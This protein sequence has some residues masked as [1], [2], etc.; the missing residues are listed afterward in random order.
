MTGWSAG[1]A[2]DLIF[3]YGGND[4]L[5]GNGGDDTLRGGR[6]NDVLHGGAGADAL[7]D[8]ATERTAANGGLNLHNL[9]DGGAD[10][11]ILSSKTTVNLFVTPIR[12]Q[13]HGQPG[14][15]PGTAGGRRQ[16]PAARRS[17]HQ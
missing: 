11:D 7:Y 6:G 5:L 16:R 8:N 15:P 2:D 4:T 10:N 12:R 9:L 17:C 14:H 13:P 1:L 3:G